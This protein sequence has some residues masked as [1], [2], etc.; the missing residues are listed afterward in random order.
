MCQGTCSNC[1]N[2][3]REVDSA[4]NSMIIRLT[5]NVLKDSY[6]KIENW[7]N[8]EIHFLGVW[9]Q[10]YDCKEFDYY[11]LWKHLCSFYKISD[12]FTL[13]PYLVCNW[14]T[15]YFIFVS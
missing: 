9:T 12:P 4:F 13:C 8:R 14:E 10:I 2:V 5:V 11:G 3:C 6:W 7:K 1:S 15:E